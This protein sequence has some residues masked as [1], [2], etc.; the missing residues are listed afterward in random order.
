MFIMAMWVE[1]SDGR[2]GKS[3]G[4]GPHTSFTGC[5]YMRKTEE[6]KTTPEV[7][8]WGHGAMLS[9]EMGN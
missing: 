5:V 3:F 8:G 7:S 9:S 2:T 6:V 1:R 4:G